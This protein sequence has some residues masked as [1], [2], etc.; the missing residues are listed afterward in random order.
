VF[1]GVFTPEEDDGIADKELEDSTTV[2][3]QTLLN[4]FLNMPLRTA[5]FVHDSFFW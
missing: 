5:S 2:D 4:A 1:S 3:V